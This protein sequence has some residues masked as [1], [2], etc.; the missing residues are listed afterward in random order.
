M[1]NI[2]AIW[3]KGNE[4]ILKDESLDST[5]IEK[6]ISESS[7]RISSKL[8]KA[9]RSG[10][11]FTSLSVIAFVY[12]IFFYLN[13]I[14]ILVA[15]IGFTILSVISIFYLFTQMANIKKQDTSIDNLHKLLVSRIKFFNTQFQLVIHCLAASVVFLTITLNLTMEN[16]D[17]VFELRKILLLS[18]YY[19]VVY[20]GLIYVFKKTNNIYLKRLRNALFNL[21]ENSLVTIDSEEKKHKTVKRWFLTII[22]VLAVAGLVVALIKMGI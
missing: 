9:I 2:E 3:D 20:I 19:I 6:S 21:E 16:A 10:I 12:N 4:Q 22:V 1:D 18:V 5:F 8:I 15:I 11:I 17:G 7:K 14:P 13:N